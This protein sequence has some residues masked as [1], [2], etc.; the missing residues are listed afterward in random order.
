MNKYSLAAEAIKERVSMP[1]AIA[2]YAPIPAPRRN[3]IPCPVHN[4]TNFNL[5]FSDRLYHC[6]V[7]GSGGDVISFTQ[8]VFGIDFRAAIEKINNDFEIG[9]PIKRRM[10]LREQREAEQKHREI[11]AERERKEQEERAYNDLYTSLCNEWHRLSKNKEVYAPKSPDAE[12]NPLFVE[13]LQK[14]DY[15]EY[16]IDSFLTNYTTKAW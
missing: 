8:H 3:R 15:Q 13:A 11:M 2:R 6:F 9:L 16:L 7:C 12:W 5:G 4:G 14:I 10:T 1:D